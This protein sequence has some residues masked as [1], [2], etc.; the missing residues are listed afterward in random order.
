[1]APTTP[2]E[3]V[4]DRAD[5]YGCP[6]CVDG[7]DVLAVSGAVAEAARARAGEGPTLIEAR[8]TATRVIASDP[9]ELPPRRGAGGVAGARPDRATTSRRYRD[10]ESTPSAGRDAV[11]GGAPPC[12]AVEA[13]RCRTR[14]PSRG[15]DAG[16]AASVGLVM[17]EVTYK[18]AI[19][20]ALADSL[21]ADKDIILFGEDIAAAGG[22][23]K[24]TEGL[25]ESSVPRGARLP[26]S[27][28]A[29]VG[30]AIG[31]ATSGLRPV[32]EI[33]FADFARECFD[34]LVDQLPKLPLHDRRPAPA[35]R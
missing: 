19:K 18:E 33:M 22:V 9:G 4:A 32:A 1:M 20:R 8:R 6:A 24:M 15:A 3:R 35:C 23:F 11:A 28:H 29:I 30:A 13:R 5:A 16:V 14:A 25:E 34:Q 27:E 7:N 2:I 12:R 10:R 17:G 26:M 21:A 31:A